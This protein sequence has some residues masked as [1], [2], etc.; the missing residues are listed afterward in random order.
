MIRN[1]RLTV[2]AAASLALVACGAPDDEPADE[3]MAETGAAAQETV[4]GEAMAAGSEPSCFLRG[5][6]V[7]EAEGRTSPL[8]RVEFTYP[9]GEGLLCY[10]APSARG[11]EVMGALV[12][13]DEPWRAGANEPTTIHLTAPA[14][15]GGVPLDAGSYSMYTIPGEDEWE[16]FLNSNYERWGIP[17]SPDVRATEVGSFTVTPGTTDDMVE[18]LT[19][20]FEDGAI[21]MTWENTRIEIP[22]GAGGM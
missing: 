11:R 18:T 10:G 6:T 17:I 9:G 22:V 21:V 14:S 1:C 16:W 8:R 2:L 15:I 13:Y 3:Q 20:A 7:E 4:P 12:P 19:Y 5:A